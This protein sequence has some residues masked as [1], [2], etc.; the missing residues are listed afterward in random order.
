MSLLEVEGSVLD[1]LVALVAVANILPILPV[2]LTTLAQAPR[3]DRRRIG[4]SALLLGNV[5]AF[6][7]AYG[8]G[9]LLAAMR[10]R[11]DDLRIAGGLVLLIFAIYDLLFSREQRKEALGELAEAEAEPA[12][13]TVGLVPLGVPL[14]VGPATLTAGLVVAESFGAAILALGLA[15]NVVVNGAILLL[16]QRLMDFVGHGT[17][18]ATGKIFGLLL[19]T[20]AVTMIRIGVEN[21]VG[22]AS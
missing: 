10:S 14:M 13:E 21:L 19:A 16:G 9:F 11:V 8:G 6:L 18:R 1:P 4:L 12:G 5:V 22:G 2:V 7:F 15:I 17:L 20:I 3:H